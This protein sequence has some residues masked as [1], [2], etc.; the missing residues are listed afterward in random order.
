M[1]LVR[2]QSIHDFQ[3]SAKA[4]EQLAAGRRGEEGE[5]RPERRRP[6]RKKYAREGIATLEVKWY[7]EAGYPIVSYHIG[8]PAS[9]L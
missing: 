6:R 1:P 2:D 3:F 8:T 5:R 9:Y 4:R 7:G